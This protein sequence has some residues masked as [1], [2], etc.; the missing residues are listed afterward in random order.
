MKPIIHDNQL[1]LNAIFIAAPEGGFTGYFVEFPEAIAEGENEVEVEQNLVEA[2]RTILEYRREE[3]ENS[4][5][6]GKKTKKF[7]LEFA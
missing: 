3:N 5:F 6:E 1:E 4:D 7:N 2:L